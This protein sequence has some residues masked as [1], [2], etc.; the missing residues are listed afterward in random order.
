MKTLLSYASLLA[1]ATSLHAAQ[2]QTPATTHDNPTPAKGPKTADHRAATYQGP[3]VHKD[4]K[5]LGQ[6]M[7]QK[8]KPTDAI[9]TPVRELP[10]KK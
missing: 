4:S 6:K 1:L 10:V 7:V 9:Q 3:N 8:S 2:A 5:A